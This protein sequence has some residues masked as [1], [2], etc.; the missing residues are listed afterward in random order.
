MC[1]IP[2]KYRNADFL[3]IDKLPENYELLSCDTLIYSGKAD[4]YTKN[5]NS[6]K[7][8][9]KNIKVTYEDT[10]TINFSGG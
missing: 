1:R 10:V 3:I 5:I 8:I 2:E 4:Y 9:N 7:E 6:I